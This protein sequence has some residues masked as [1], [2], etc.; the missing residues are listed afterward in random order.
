MASTQQCTGEN[1]EEGKSTENAPQ[2]QPAVE[3]DVNLD[4][5]LAFD[6]GSG[7]MPVCLF[8]FLCMLL[9]VAYTVSCLV[10]HQWAAYTE[11]YA[12]CYCYMQ[13]FCIDSDVRYVFVQDDAAMPADSFHS[14]FNDDLSKAGEIPSVMDDLPPAME[15]DSVLG[16]RTKTKS[17]NVV[18]GDAWSSE[19]NPQQMNSV[20][21]IQRVTA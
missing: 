7:M 3:A 4:T 1:T 12:L 17:P 6:D 14:F 10:C 18:L 16:G 19:G 2:L 21:S 11:L 9:A 15:V 20:E 13:R 5:Y 8:L